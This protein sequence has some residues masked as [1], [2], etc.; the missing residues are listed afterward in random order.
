MV[1]TAPISVYELREEAVVVP[2][3][4][5]IANSHSHCKYDLGAGLAINFKS[6]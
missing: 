6:N 2:S 3:L 1:L 5:A 4:G